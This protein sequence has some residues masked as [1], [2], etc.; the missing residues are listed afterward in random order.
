MKPAVFALTLGLVA[1]LPPR[2]AA[3]QVSNQSFQVTPATPR[4]TVG[5][6]VVLNF[7]V[8]LDERD[9][10]FDT[11]PD[12]IGDLPP[13]VRILSVDK[14]QR[15]PD[16]IFH[17]QARLAFYRPGRQPVPVFGLPFMRSV[18]GL[19]RAT[20]ASDSAFV[21]VASLL[22]AGNP[23]LKDIKGLERRS[24]P[25]LL[26]WIIGALLL[27]G[28]IAI[29][30]RRRSAR[31]AS[32]PASR[33]SEPIDSRVPLSPYE[34]AL[35]QLGVIEREDWPARGQP[36]RH[37]EAV[38]DVLRDYL[39]SAEAVPAR[40]RTSAEILWSL[41]PHLSEGELRER[42]R[43][44]LEQADLVKFARLRPGKAEAGQFLERCRALLQDWHQ[45]NAATSVS[46]AVL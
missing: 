15:T 22:P 41:P 30:L 44:I 7:R 13:A 21:E 20:L 16:R 9:L 37:Y 38:T 36:A 34:L 24:A 29:Y 8:R 46:D 6:T 43:G 18:K 1:I 2:S 40:E 19:Q 23:P 33:E 14:L 11:I 26:P 3:A 35:E 39:E 12:P 28:G 4:A 10:L 32:S 27:L 5:D 42:L 17:G 45:T 25:A 31:S